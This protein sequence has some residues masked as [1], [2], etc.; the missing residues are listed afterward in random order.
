VRALAAGEVQ[1]F[2]AWNLVGRTET[3]ILLQDFQSRTCSWL[4]A[5]PLATTAPTIKG[6]TRLYFGSGVR[7]PGSASVK[8]LMPFHR[9]YA[10]TLLGSAAKRLLSIS[11]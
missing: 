6:R 3:E 5:E 8:A 11:A 7:H 1:Q 10:Q 4:C 2:A 9:F